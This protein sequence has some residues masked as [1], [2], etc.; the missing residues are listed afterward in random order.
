[1]TKNLIQQ[2]PYK[3]FILSILV[4]NFGVSNRAVFAL[5]LKEAVELSRAR[6]PNI[7][8]ARRKL[9]EARA[10][11]WKTWGTVAPTVTSAL[12]YQRQ[13]D[14]LT[15]TKPRFDGQSFNFYQFET[16]ITQPIL[17]RGIVNG[18]L[19]SRLGA[20]LGRLSFEI[21]DRDLIIN[22]VKNFFSLLLKKREVETLKKSKDVREQSLQIAQ[23]RSRI[24]RAQ[25]LDVLQIQTQIALL[26]PKI[27]KS[28]NE[29]S[30]AAAQLA[31][32]I[33]EHE[34]RSLQ[35]EGSLDFPQPAELVKSLE[36]F[37]AQAPELKSKSLEIQ[38]SEY[39]NTAAM[40]DYW[41]KLF[42]EGTWSRSGFKKGDLTNS[43]STQWS[44]GLTLSI[45]LFQGGQGWFNNQILNA[46]VGQLRAQ[47]HQLIDQWAQDQV[48]ANEELE[49]AEAMIQSTRR[50]FDL[51]Q[52]A[53]K[54]ARD[55]YKI[56][57]IDA[58]QLLNTEQDLLDSELALN[59]SKFDFIDK[60]TKYTKVYGVGSDILF[61]RLVAF[62]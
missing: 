12:S 28:E 10:T 44:V 11:E 61:E 29:L 3:F 41:P 36:P 60:L 57:N 35:V 17:Q 24:G 26:E 38:A 59:Q 54:V 37:K 20:D 25:R 9:D 43:D 21:A 14:A 40:T 52:Q 46:Q 23:R 7:E 1:M 16:T 22:V 30:S 8:E 49:T 34:R 42:G 53:V 13:A 19:G 39:K 33:G 27:Q 56:S 62:K 55:D 47:Q 6:S 32:L 58:L 18:V 45:P 15:A 50:A 4:A 51:A 48:T 31:I 5:T 2:L